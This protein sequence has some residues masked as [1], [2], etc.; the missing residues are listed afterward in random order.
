MDAGEALEFIA[1]Y[2]S[3]TNRGETQCLKAITTLVAIADISTIH[4]GLVVQNVSH[5]L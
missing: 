4:F 5:F 2:Q 1:D 3:K